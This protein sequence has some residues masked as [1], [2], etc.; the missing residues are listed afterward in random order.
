[1]NFGVITAITCSVLTVPVLAQDRLSASTKGSLLIYSKV[2]LKW[3]RQSDGSYRLTQDSFF[4]ISNDY[5]TDVQVQLMF[6][7]GDPPLD[8]V[9][10]DNDLIEREHPGWNFVDCLITLTANQP[11]YWAASTGL[12]VACAPFTILD[13]GSPPGRPDPEIRGGRILRGMIYAWAV[14]RGRPPEFPENVQIRHNHLSGDGQI[15]NYARGTAARYNTYAVQVVDNPNWMNNGDYVGTAGV[16]RLNGIEYQNAFSALVLNFHASRSTALSGGGHL[17][18]LDTDIT[19]HPVDA[20]LRLEDGNGPVTTKAVFDIWNEN[21]VRFF[22]VDRCIT[23]WDQTLASRYVSSAF[24]FFLRTNLG[25]NKGKARISG[26]AS[27]RCPFARD[28]ALLG[29]SIEQLSFV[30]Q[31]P[32]PPSKS[33]A[34][35][36]ITLVG[37]GTK[38]ATVRYDLIAGSPNQTD[39][40]GEAEKNPGT[41]LTP[42]AGG[43]ES[44][45]VEE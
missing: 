39:P 32:L 6:I 2:E 25:T 35:S 41:P 7:N 9:F 8:A 18:S 3:A 19:L 24:N 26:V 5:P 36:A 40:A 28:A 10:E 22:G 4:D 16:I 43:V 29:L 44:V 17:V 42:R 45:P 1:M 33:F 31:S 34:H 15:I 14:K 11:A 21:E 30:A 38:S 12:P 20:D 23:C 27:S 37:Q 13:P